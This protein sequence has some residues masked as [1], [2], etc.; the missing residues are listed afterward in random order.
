MTQFRSTQSR[1]IKSLTLVSSRFAMQT[2]TTSSATFPNMGDC[3]TSSTPQS[4]MLSP[5]LSRPMGLATGLSS[6]SAPWFVLS[7]LQLWALLTYY[8]LLGLT[9]AP[10][11][12]YPGFPGRRLKL[13][14]WV[15]AVSRHGLLLLS[16]GLIFF[17]GTYLSVVS[18]TVL[19]FLSDFC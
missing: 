10:F 2:T 8:R 1:S 5:S 11:G 14:T 17:T 16:L 4:V 15:L 9:M 19:R 12:S 13:V 7:P 6:I 18:R 3:Y